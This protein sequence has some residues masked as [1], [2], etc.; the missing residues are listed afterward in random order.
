MNAFAETILADTRLCTGCLAC[1]LACG[2]HWSESMDP[3]CSTIRVHRDDASGTID[4]KILEGCDFCRDRETPMCVSVCIPR[5]LSL[6][7]KHQNEGE[8][9]K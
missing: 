9:K 2:F 5:A 1:E 6:G 4:V 7:R 8:A 3:S